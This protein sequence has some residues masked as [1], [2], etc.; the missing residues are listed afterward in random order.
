[1]QE[2][3]MLS[4]E[5]ALCALRKGQ[6]IAYPTESVYGMGCVA[7]DQ[8]AVA[9]L[10]AY[11]QS[12]AGKGYIV[13]VGS[14]KAAMALVCAR[15]KAYLQ[16]HPRVLEGVTCVFP[17]S[18]CAPIWCQLQ[19]KIALRISTHPMCIRLCK[20]LGQPLIS[21]SCNASGQPVLMDSATI[22]QTF[23]HVAGV[24]Q[25]PVGGLPPTKV[26]DVLTGR[27]FRA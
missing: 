11:K 4:I 5:Q 1:M 21:T 9:K 25:G 18:G 2:K 26:I 23:S 12:P 8:A 7:T 6:V 22:L 24:L 15:S 16:K 14:S 19:G 20:Q 3:R 27:V 10:N 13:L 17:A